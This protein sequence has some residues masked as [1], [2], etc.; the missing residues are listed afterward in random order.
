MRLHTLV[1]I[2]V[3]AAASG[4]PD[5]SRSRV[6]GTDPQNFIFFGFERSRIADPAFL[7]TPGIAG[8]QLKYSWREL[9][10]VRG[11]YD[12][13]AIRGD[14]KR[15][16]GAGKRLFIQL[17]DVS[18]VDTLIN[19]PQYLVE[20]PAFHGGVAAQYEFA[21]DNDSAPTLEGWVARRWDRAVQARFGALLRR[22]GAE[23]DGRIAGLNLA[24]TSVAFGKTGQFFPAGYSYDTYYDGILTFMSLA[25]EAFHHS[26]V[27][28]YANFMPG[29]E[30]PSLDRGY[31]RGV[32]RHAD[33]IGMGIGG[34]DLLP[35]R[36]FQRHNSLPLIRQRAATTV[37]GMA[38]QEGNLADVDRRTGRRV[39]VR[40]LADYARDELHL[41]YIFWGTEEPYWSSEV[42]PYLRTL[43]D[44]GTPP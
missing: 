7:S 30:L 29:E 37:A 4:T 18:F 10:P 25:R 2:L 24:E 31:L 44:D 9:E 11:Q 1:S 16:E 32:Y 43:R 23:F 21:A 36:W 42:L 17:Q 19:V 22:L 8:A 35:L 39:T 38:V 40:Y 28:V 33:R 12:F 34:P 26:D 13:D 5:G 27:I 20:D 3:L 14:L 6:A 15:L 41:D